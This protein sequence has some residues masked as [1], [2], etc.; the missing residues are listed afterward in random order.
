MNNRFYI[1]RETDFPHIHNPMSVWM[2]HVATLIPVRFLKG[3]LRDYFG[4]RSG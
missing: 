2:Q 1:D 3:G 4:H